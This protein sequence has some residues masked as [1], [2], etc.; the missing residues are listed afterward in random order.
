MTDIPVPP[1][2]VDELSSTEDIAFQA[3]CWVGTCGWA[4]KIEHADNYADGGD[5]HP[6]DAAH[7]AA[8]AEGAAHLAEVHPLP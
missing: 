5:V 6:A 3:V 7:D 1:I 2:V 4:G 8:E